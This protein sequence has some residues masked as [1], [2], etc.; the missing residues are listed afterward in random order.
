M[1]TCSARSDYYQ[2][3]HE[4]GN[5]QKKRILA[6]KRGQHLVSNAAFSDTDNCLA[7]LMSQMRDDEVRD[8]I[9]ADELIWREAALRMSALWRKE[10]QKQDY[11]IEWIRRQELLAALYCL[12]ESWCLM[13]HWAV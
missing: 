9:M 12:Q 2:A 10:N 13:F 5:G 7:K 8:T 3:H 11:I 6:V 4:V 1:K